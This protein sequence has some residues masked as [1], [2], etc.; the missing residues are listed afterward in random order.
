MSDDTLP[1]SQRQ[2][3]EGDTPNL[4]VSIV[5][6]DGNPITLANVVSLKLTEWIG[7]PFGGYPATIN[8]RKI[9]NALNANGVTV[10]T[11]SGL[12]TWLLAP[13]DTA[14]QS[15]DLSVLEEKHFFR[16]DLAYTATSGTM[17]KSYPDYYV[18][19]RKTITK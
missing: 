12:V 5:D 18:V 10:D 3:D 13:A 16:F 17:Y 19:Q 1:D 7:G 4:Q 9:Q 8:G 15:R 2:W 14:M 11:S 6:G